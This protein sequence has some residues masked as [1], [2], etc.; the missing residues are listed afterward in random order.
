MYAP[1]LID[2]QGEVRLAGAPELRCYRDTC[3]DM[4]E[5]P[6]CAVRDLGFVL[7]REHPTAVHLTL[8]PSLVTEPALA[9]LFYYLAEAGPERV[10]L[11]YLLEDWHHDVIRGVHEAFL[12]LEDLVAA[13]R[14][15]RPRA[16]YQAQVHPAQL[17]HHGAYEHWAPLLAVWGLAGGRAPQ[18]VIEL[19][20]SFSLLDRA[21][22]VR[23][24]PDSDRLVFEH[25]GDAHSFY[26]PYRN[27]AA[28][29][30]DFEEQPDQEFAA[31]VAGAYRAALGAREPRFE[32]VDAAPRT[33]GREFRRSRYDRLILPW[34]AA[35][36]DRFVTSLW[37]LRTSY[38]VEH[39]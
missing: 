5:W 19:L 6:D 12:R 24:P 1:I 37:T 27:L 36:G 31:A 23:N 38:A 29:G 17:L 30:R 26:S 11:S 35:T 13:A 9:A 28:I 32:A 4:S 39:A 14:K 15:W 22:V 21:S 18:S 7:V 2:H 10:L 3:A 20:R 8:R 25:H 16:R 33:P 34:Q